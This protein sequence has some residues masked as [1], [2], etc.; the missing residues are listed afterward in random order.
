MMVGRL[1]SFWDGLFSGAML[2]FQ[3]VAFSDSLMAVFGLEYF[4][5]C[6]TDVPPLVS[7]SANRTHCC[8]RVVGFGKGG[9]GT[10]S[11]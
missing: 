3:G 9:S 4:F 11:P 5:T 6:N 8:H 7:S 2:N 1:R 10:M